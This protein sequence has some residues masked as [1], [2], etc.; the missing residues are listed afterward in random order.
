[1]ATHICLNELSH[2]ALGNGYAHLRQKAIS[3]INAWSW[4]ELLGVHF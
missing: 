1:M 4:V 2:I 3:L